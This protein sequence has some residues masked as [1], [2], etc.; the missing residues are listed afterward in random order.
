MD[1]EEAPVEP[2]SIVRNIKLNCSIK[3]CKT[4]LL[5]N[6]MKRKNTTTENNINFN[7]KIYLYLRLSRSK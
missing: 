3:Q 7:I 1:F 6:I 2:S 5:E 4:S